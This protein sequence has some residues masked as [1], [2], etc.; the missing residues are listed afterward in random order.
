MVEDPSLDGR[1]L[2]PGI[3]AE[4]LDEQLANITARAQ[5]VALT[6]TPVQRDNES[7]PDPLV[8]RMLADEGFQFG[9]HD[10]VVTDAELYVD[11]S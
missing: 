8:E 3:D 9:Q 6:A 7:R 10:T 2:G 11:A 4:L 1:E 5:G